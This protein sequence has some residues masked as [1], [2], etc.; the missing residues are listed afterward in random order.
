MAVGT[1]KKELSKMDDGCRVVEMCG[2]RREDSELQGFSRRRESQL[3]EMLRGSEQTQDLS[4]V[5]GLERE[6]ME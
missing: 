5:Q 4:R 3:R 6:K 1:L 2:G